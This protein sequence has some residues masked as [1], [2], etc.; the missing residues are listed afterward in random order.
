M[1]LQACQRRFGLMAHSEYHLREIDKHIHWLLSPNQ[2]FLE[3]VLSADCAVVIIP[4]RISEAPSPQMERRFFQ[5]I[6]IVVDRASGEGKSK[7]LGA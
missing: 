6:G 3:Q 7:F 4:K 1:L 2:N 5:C